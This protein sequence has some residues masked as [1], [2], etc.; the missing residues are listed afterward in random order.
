M[1]GITGITG[2]LGAI[3]QGPAA[4]FPLMLAGVPNCSKAILL[5]RIAGYVTEHAA[6]L[7]TSSIDA[8][9][10]AG[11]AGR[12]LTPAEM[13]ELARRVAS[14]VELGNYLQLHLASAGVTMQD[15]AAFFPTAQSAE[16]VP[17]L[18]M[19]VA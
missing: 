3:N 7:Q 8:M 4:I 15:F 1:I 19:E 14:I 5:S 6:A 18:G 16:A 9:V 11:A 10:T 17:V 2:L 12:D 13:E